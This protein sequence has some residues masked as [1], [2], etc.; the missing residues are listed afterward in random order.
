MEGDVKRL[1]SIA[2]REGG[3]EEG[4]GIPLFFNE[5]TGGGTELCV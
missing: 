2:G 4:D 1:R 5:E 3:K